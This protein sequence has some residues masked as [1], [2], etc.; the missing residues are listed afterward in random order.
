M[1]SF[2]RESVGDIVLGI[3]RCSVLF[4]GGIEVGDREVGWGVRV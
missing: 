2:G 1:I 4:I 3:V